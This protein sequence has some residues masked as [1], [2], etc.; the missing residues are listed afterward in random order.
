MD[1]T[2]AS[3]VSLSHDTMSGN[4]VEGVYE[5]SSTLSGDH[6]VVDRNT[7]AGMGSANGTTTIS[8]ST[9]DGNLSSGLYFAGAT[10]SLSSSTISNTIPLDVPQPP[11]PGIGV[12]V[13]VGAKLTGA[14]GCCQV[15][16]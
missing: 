4:T 3:T 15:H 13:F 12:L 10:G 2:D 1:V 14:G 5:Q 16:N 9:F 8:T 6:L 7:V 11:L